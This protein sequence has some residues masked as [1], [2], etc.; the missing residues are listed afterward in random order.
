MHDKTSPL[1]RKL[2]QLLQPNHTTSAVFRFLI[3]EAQ[4]LLGLC[5]RSMS[6]K[7]LGRIYLDLQGNI[8]QLLSLSVSSNGD[9][10]IATPLGNYPAQN[11]FIVNQKFSYHASGK[12]HMTTE[13]DLGR[14]GG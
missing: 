8:F 12:M 6:N 4:V 11:G 13:I 1:S 9:I 14:L 3:V 7:T 2:E 5:N 10:Y